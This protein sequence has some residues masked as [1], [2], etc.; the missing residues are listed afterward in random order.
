MEGKGQSG[1][2]AVELAGESG[3]LWANGFQSCELIG[4]TLK[5][6]SN[7]L[8]VSVEN[9]VT[10]IAGRIEVEWIVGRCAAALGQL[11]QALD[12]GIIVCKGIGIAGKVFSDLS[13]SQV[14][15]DQALDQAVVH[16]VSRDVADGVGLYPA[17]DRDR[18][19]GRA[20]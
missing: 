2:Y 8:C 12:K 11:G 18:N 10:L 3:E 9:D 4:V 7:L 20:G 5:V 16:G 1:E 13:R 6:A 15:R 19:A 14:H 17:K